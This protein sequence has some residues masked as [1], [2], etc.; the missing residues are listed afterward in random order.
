MGFSFSPQVITTTINNTCQEVK[1]GIPFPPQVIQIN[2]HITV[3]F[4]FNPYGIH[5]GFSQVI[6]K[7]VVQEILFAN[8][9][10]VFGWYTPC[11]YSLYSKLLFNNESLSLFQLYTD[12]E[13]NEEKWTFSPLKNQS[14]KRVKKK[15]SILLTVGRS[16]FLHSIYS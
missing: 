16:L 2:V 5:I 7:N 15:I 10:L 6:T 13:C 12:G 3:T 14:T 8:Q 9:F 1:N 4:F 11:S